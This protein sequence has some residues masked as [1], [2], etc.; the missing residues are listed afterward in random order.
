MLWN[1]VPAG[2]HTLQA[3][4]TNDANQTGHSLILP[5]TV[6]TPPLVSLTA[7][8]D[9]TLEAAATAG[10]SIGKVEF[11]QGNTLIGTVTAA[12]YTLTWNDVAAGQYILTAKAWVQSNLL[13]T[14]SA[15]VAVTVTAAA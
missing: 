3:K 11:Y 8:A 10:S 15:A 1:D 13:V 2:T 5:V 4:A 9:I 6:V 12:P 14:T 7:P